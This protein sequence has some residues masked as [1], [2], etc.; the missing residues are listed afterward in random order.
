M[1]S[2]VLKRTEGEHGIHQCARQFRK[3]AKEFEEVSVN[4]FEMDVANRATSAL[5]RDLGVAA[6]PAFH[7]YGFSDGE[8]RGVG[9]LDEVVGPSNVGKVKQRITE[10]SSTDFD[11]STFAFAE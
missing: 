5:C 9:C 4:F 6:V 11:M 8:D 10:F 7:I 2:V 1:P 3:M